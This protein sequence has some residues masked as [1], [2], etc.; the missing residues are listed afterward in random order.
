M[1]NE[2][3]QNFEPV[4]KKRKRTVI[5]PS[6]VEKLESLFCVEQWPNRARKETL[7]NELGQTE[8]FVSVW[9]QN[10]RARYKK[11]ELLARQVGKSNFNLGN[12]RKLMCVAPQIEKTPK[13]DNMQE[14]DNK[15]TSKN[16][17]AC[18][19]KPTE[20]LP[21]I[22]RI[23]ID[24]KANETPVKPQLEKKV[25]K[26]LIKPKQEAKLHI[27]RKIAHHIISLQEN[28]VRQK[29]LINCKKKSVRCKN[30]CFKFY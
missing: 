11:E 2:N 10:R 9:F 17:D 22:Q 7:A 29:N 13:N 3:S 19:I 24:R 27:D 4:K 16:I 21:F 26:I 14:A 8:H 5:P 28:Q 15:D 25:M 6:H 18:Q 23:D 1:S 12:G 30:N 20:L